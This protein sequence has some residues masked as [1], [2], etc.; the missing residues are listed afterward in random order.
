MGARPEE[1]GR[2][3]TSPWGWEDPREEA[4]IG[5]ALGD[6]VAQSGGRSGGTDIHGQSGVERTVYAVIY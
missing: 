6:G 5:K 2:G 4:A 3:R 1:S